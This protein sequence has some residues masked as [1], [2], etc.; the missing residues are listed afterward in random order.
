MAYNKY[1]TDYK[2]SRA[3]VKV[4]LDN[5]TMLVGK[6]N[7]FDDCCVIIDSCL[8]NRDKIISIVPEA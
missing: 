8:V 2:T 5:K 6:V 4:Y 1:L 3:K 7:D